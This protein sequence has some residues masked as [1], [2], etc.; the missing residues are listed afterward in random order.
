MQAA[1][2]RRRRCPELPLVGGQLQPTSPRL[3]GVTGAPEAG[4]M[5]STSALRLPHR[6]PGLGMSALPSQ[7]VWG[8][9][10]GCPLPCLWSPHSHCLALGSGHSCLYSS[11]SLSFLT[12]KTWGTWS[13]LQGSS[14]QP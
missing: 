9:R 11:P 7:R 2:H 12:Y 5:G 10:P 3:A 13:A 8:G 1:Q 4:V 14:H 6:M